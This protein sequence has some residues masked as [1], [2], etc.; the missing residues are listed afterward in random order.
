MKQRKETKKWSGDRWAAF[1]FKGERI[2][3]T[4]FFASIIEAEKAILNSYDRD[5]D[6]AR[7]TYTMEG[8][9]RFD[10]KRAK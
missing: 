7:I 1:F 3:R 10:N 5:W 9:Y 2:I 4:L 6:S 8:W